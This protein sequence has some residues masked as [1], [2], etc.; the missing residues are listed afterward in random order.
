MYIIIKNDRNQTI[1]HKGDWPFEYLEDCLNRGE[2]LVVISLY[3]NTLKVPK[4]K[5]EMYGEKVWDWDNFSLTGAFNVLAQ[6]F[7]VP[8]NKRD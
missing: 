8:L 3:S 6:S 5:G 1:T 4:L 2:N 7:V